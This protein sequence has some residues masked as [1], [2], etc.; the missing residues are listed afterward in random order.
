MKFALALL[1]LGA[2]LVAGLSFWDGEDC[3]GN[4]IEVDFSFAR[5]P[6]YAI[7]DGVRSF[8]CKPAAI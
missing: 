3:T 5:E 2:S 8:V 6:C 4:Q 1:S 7:P